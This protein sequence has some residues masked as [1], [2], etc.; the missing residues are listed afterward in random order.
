M[1][2]ALGRRTFL[3]GIGTG[4]GIAIGLPLLEAMIPT[5]LIGST[6]ATAAAEA[7]QVKNRFILL[8]YPNG[9]HTPNWYPQVPED[10]IGTGATPAQ[11]VDWPLTPAMEPLERHRKDML[12]VGGLDVPLARMDRN[13]DHAKAM[14]CYLTGVRIRMTSS[15]DIQAGISADQ[16]MANKIGG[17][18]RFPSLEM[19]MDYGRMEGGCDPG[20]ACI[21]SNNASWKNETTPAIK[22]VNP[23]I[24][25]DR[26]FGNMQHSDHDGEKKDQQETYNRSILD[27]TREN[28]SKI[29]KQL[30]TADRL[31]VDE[32]LT[33]IR[34]IERRLDAP[35]SDVKLPPGVVRPT[36]VPDTFRE[37]FHLMADLQILAIQQDLTRISTLLLGVEQSRRTYNEIGI[38]EEHHGLTHHAGD[39]AKIAK[40]CRIDNYCTQQFAIYLDKMKAAK[41]G[42]KPLLDNCTV[43]LGNGNGDAARHDHASCMTVIAG[44]GGGTLTP[45]RYL[46]YDAQNLSNLWL[47]LMDR[48]GVHEERFGDSTGRLEGLS[49]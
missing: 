28:L 34:E 38:P 49:I 47:S 2:K 9:I 15:D 27:Y 35:P 39:P 25:F 13:G 33:S 30:G 6:E 4:A 29:N 10:F 23:R 22:E 37:H 18:T 7:V 11:M 1:R 21:Y 44:K 3:R 31:R 16:L 19:G 14:G 41:E 46:K 45:G 20:Y 12:L 40:M 17:Q 26:L 8:Y 32:Y 24:V 43:L 36:R 5:S 48:M 42:D